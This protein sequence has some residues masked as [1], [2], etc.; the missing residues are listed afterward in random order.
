MSLLI[1]CIL[2]HASYNFAAEQQINTNDILQK[3]ASINDIDI[4]NLNAI[5]DVSYSLLFNNFVNFKN[6]IVNNFSKTNFKK[7][8]NEFI[9]QIY[10][11]DA[12]DVIDFG[13]SIPAITDQIS[14][15]SPEASSNSTNSSTLIQDQSNDRTIQN[16]SSPGEIT[17][18]DPT[19]TPAESPQ[20]NEPQPE[21]QNSQSEAPESSGQT[22]LN[23]SESE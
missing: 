5:E 19:A 14:S 15:S 18:N 16:Q 7:L 3:L 21:S 9:D 12:S 4:K 8:C 23:P 2:L 13:I 10:P 20:A 1:T 6:F 11:E 17:L 22:S